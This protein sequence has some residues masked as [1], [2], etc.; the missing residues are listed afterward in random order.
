MGSLRTGQGVKKEKEY[1]QKNKS[2]EGQ[3]QPGGEI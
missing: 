2:E 1:D 3:G